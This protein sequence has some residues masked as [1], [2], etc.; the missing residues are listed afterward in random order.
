[1]SEPKHSPAPWRILP[2]PDWPERIMGI[3]DADNDEVVVTD[4]GVYP[5][6]I[7]DAYLIAAAPELL[8]ACVGMLSIFE[9]GAARTG[10]WQGPFADR[11]RAAIAKAN[12]KPSKP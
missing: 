1:M 10:G 11:V 2:N 6:D 8:E 9:D 12:G 4:C 3:V 5:P 7:E